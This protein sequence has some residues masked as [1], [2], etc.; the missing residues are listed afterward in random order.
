LVDVLKLKMF[1]ILVVLGRKFTTLATLD[2][3]AFA[4]ITQHFDPSMKLEFAGAPGPAGPR[5]RAI[6]RASPRAQPKRC[7]DMASRSFHS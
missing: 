3:A 4:P 7:F 1:G 2:D 6:F 5:V